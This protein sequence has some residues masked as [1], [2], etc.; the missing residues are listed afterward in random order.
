MVLM[1]FIVLLVAVVVLFSV[2]NASPVSVAFLAWKFDASLAIVIFLA[3]AVGVV[4]GVAIALSARRKRM[5]GKK[6]PTEIPSKP[7]VPGSS[8]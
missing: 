6:S 5:S 2:Q 4:I 1:I 7:D 3:L 8:F